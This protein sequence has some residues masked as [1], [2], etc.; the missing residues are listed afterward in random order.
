MLPAVQKRKS[1]VDLDTAL[2]A[3]LLEGGQKV[4]D[5]VP[6]VTVQT[7]A[8]ALLVEVVGNQTDAAAQN[9]QTVEDTHTHVV[10]DLLAGEGT[11]VAEQ[12]NE[13]DSDAAVDVED[14]VVLLGGGNSLDGNGVVEQLGAGEVLLN[15]LLDEL[16]TQIRV[17][18]GLDL[19]ANTGDQ[20]VLLAHDVH[21]VTGAQPLVEGLGEL[22]GGTVQRTTETRTNGQQTRD[23]GGD[24]VLAGTGGDDGV[25][26]TRHGGTVVGS[27]HENHL[28]ELASVAGQ[29]AAEPQQR[30]NTANADVLPEDIGDG[31]TGVEQLL[32]TVVGDGGDE[33]SGLTDETKLLGPRVVNGDLGNDGL[34]SGLDG[35]LGNLGIVDLLEGLGQILEGLGNVDTSI[36]HGLVLEDSSLHLGVGG[37]TGV[38]ELNLGLE[39][40]GAGTNGPGDHGL[41]DGAVLDGLDHTVLLNTTDLT[42]EDEDLAIRLGLVTEQVVNEGGAGVTVTTNGNTL[43]DTVGVLRDNVVK[44]VGH[45]TGLGDV[46]DGTLAVQLGGDD[47][48]HHT[49]GVT[50]LVRTGLDTTDGGGADDRN[51]LLL[52]SDHDLTGTA[53]GD[54]LGDDGDGADLGAVHQLHGGGVDGTGGGEVDDSVNVGVLGHGLLDILV[55]GKEGLAGAPVHLADELATEGVDDTGHRG[56]GTLA[57][58]VKVEHAL[59]GS[60]LHA[61]AEL[62]NIRCC[63][64]GGAVEYSLYEASCLVV[65][66]G[67]VKGRE[68]TA[69]RVEAGDVVVGRLDAVAGKSSRGHDESSRVR[70]WLER[71]G[72]DGGRYSRGGNTPM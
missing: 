7:G 45:T 62:V 34:G 68:G 54:T 71:R 61:T 66:K 52:G 60:G 59:H 11:A 26:G 37:G 58:E 8:Q 35:A 69:G 57:N 42:E 25:H 53:L 32:A 41:G 27:E 36:T 20:L 72:R 2:G 33:G 14:Q 24:E 4:G 64:A 65:E 39:H 56:G 63:T 16:D 5:V 13:A 29:A 50:D 47:V 22:L 17:V 48:V 43:V 15:E 30:H 46:A 70:R 28:E 10:L 12:V 55:D 44:L 31:H 23:Q 9:E 67:V 38:T 21:E 1:H 51:A 18:A 6:G 40:A 3:A 19:V 49:T